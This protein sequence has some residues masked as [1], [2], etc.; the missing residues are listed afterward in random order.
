MERR[1][2]TIPNCLVAM[3]LAAL[4]FF[5]ASAAETDDY[6][7]AA[8]DWNT[9]A[10]E[11]SA[12]EADDRFL[13]VFWN[14]ENFYD[15]FD[16]GANSSDSEF[17][18]V[19]K[20][21]WTKKRFTDKCNA[22]GKTVLSIASKYGRL[23]DVIAVAEVENSIVLKR[24]ADSDV[25]RKCG[26]RYV[27][28]DSPDRRGIDVAMLYMSSTVDVIASRPVH[29]YSEDGKPMRT[30]DMLYSKVLWHTATKGEGDCK[31][32]NAD[33]LHIIVN[34]H[35][36]KYSGSKSSAGARIAAMKALKS[37]CDSTSAV[38][39]A[40]IVMT[41]DFND[42]ADGNQ[43]SLLGDG[44]EN[45]SL[46]SYGK[47]QGRGTKTGV[48]SIRFNGKWELID[49]FI[50]S[51]DIAGQS[52]MEIYDASFLLEKDKAHTGWKP[53]RTYTGPRYNG[54]ISDHLPI[55]LEVADPN[56]ALSTL[57]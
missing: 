51:K 15:Y 42:T 26:Y 25:L 8:A 4:C 5:P 49:H 6:S 22:F 20:R 29:V 17:S 56:P 31:S 19:G 12:A 53:R 11:Q 57:H 14:L 52:T 36:S 43:F 39:D 55:V 2:Y 47:E 41:G 44:Y 7:D 48:G 32:G 45:L 30:R 54:G 13:A 10:F 40:P 27:H 46:K 24:I 9:V 33:T 28:F 16:D 38:S 3:L 1:L 34:H 37:L 35:P 18:A 23:P 50:V 21:H